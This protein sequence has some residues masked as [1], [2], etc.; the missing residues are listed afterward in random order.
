MQFLI[1]GSRF[2]GCSRAC[3]ENFSIGLLFADSY[4][5][6]ITIALLKQVS[7]R[8]TTNFQSNQMQ[9]CSVPL[10]SL[11]LFAFNCLSC[12]II[13]CRNLS[14]RLDYLDFFLLY[15]LQASALEIITPYT[16]RKKCLKNKKIFLIDTNSIFIYINIYIC[17]LRKHFFSYKK[18]YILLNLQLSMRAI[19]YTI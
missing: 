2:I 17:T 12:V 10:F 11:S 8:A 9:P 3:R 7:R 15:T 13:P 18:I 6:K 16:E 1:D 19:V 4:Q 14:S 5:Q